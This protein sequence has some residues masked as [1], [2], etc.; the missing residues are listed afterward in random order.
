MAINYCLGEAFIQPSE[1]EAVVFYDSPLLTFDRIVK[2]SVPVAPAGR[3]NFLDACRAVLGVK[4]RLVDEFEQILGEK[5][6]LL[7]THHHMAHAASCFYPSPFEE[8]AILT[9]DGVGE[10]A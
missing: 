7:V 5:P 1:L 2:N 6:R 3:D 9:I 4:A 10:W 8:A